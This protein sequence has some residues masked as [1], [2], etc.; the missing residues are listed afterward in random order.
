MLELVLPSPT[1][2]RQNSH[3]EALSNYAAT[4]LSLNRREQAEQ[5]W[6]Q[7]VKT[8]PSHFEAVEHLV[9]LLCGEHRAKDAVDIISFVETS[10]RQTAYF[11]DR[12]PS[13]G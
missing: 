2:R 10:L 7:A 3:V 13:L 1:N 6:R 9:G 12:T 8:R 5:Y 4:L 11:S